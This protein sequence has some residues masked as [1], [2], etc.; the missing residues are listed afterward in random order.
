MRLLRTDTKEPVLESSNDDSK[1]YA[2]LS[3]RWFEDEEEIAYQDILRATEIAVLQSRRGWYKLNQCRKQAVEDGLRHVWLDTCCI[4]KS[5][6]H[7][8]TE[9]INSIYRWYEKP[10]GRDEYG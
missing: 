5:S 3:H 1:E 4:D 9:S 7:E 6:S 10:Q 8:L 2:I